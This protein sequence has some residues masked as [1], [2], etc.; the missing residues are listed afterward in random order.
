MFRTAY[1]IFD[2]YLRL[3]ILYQKET[4]QIEKEKMKYIMPLFFL[5]ISC[6]DEPVQNTNVVAPSASHPSANVTTSRTAI[7]NSGYFID[8]PS[9]HK[10]DS[11]PGIDFKVYYFTPFDTTLN[12]GEAGI[13]FG[14]HPDEAP[15][16]REYTK[17]EFSQVWLGQTVKWNE[18]TTNA[19]TQRE[20][21]VNMADSSMIHCWCYSDNNSDLEKLFLMVNTISK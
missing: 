21:F 11:Q 9:T 18:Y 20:T 7:G 4:D 15:P 5:L 14:T 8:L 12:R 13:Y 1:G 10:I 3:C 6:A 2:I 19:Y 16:S 17:K